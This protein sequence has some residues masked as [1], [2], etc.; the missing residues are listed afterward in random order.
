[1]V[2]ESFET[3]AHALSALFG[4]GGESHDLSFGAALS[5]GI[6]T[7]HQN[8]G[9]FCESSSLTVYYINKQH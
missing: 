5:P 7:P 3:C 2:A 8:V 1:M 9:Q 6:I 4:D